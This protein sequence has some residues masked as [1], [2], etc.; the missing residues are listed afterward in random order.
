MKTRFSLQSVLIAGVVATVAMTLFTYM[1]PL[2]GFEMDIPKML[3]TTMGEP[4]I[5]GWIAHFM[6]GEIL[7]ISFGAIFL[8]KTNK[9]AN[10]KSGTLFSLI[11]WFAAQV[12]AMPMMSIM[13]G[14]SYISGFFSGSMMVAMASLVGHLIYGAI[15]GS[16]YKPRSITA[17]ARA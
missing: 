7:A 8:K 11:P 10:L 9:S 12:M 6:I 16:I 14:G 5:V 17:N 1:A 15:L 13:T 3:A 4:I 2:M